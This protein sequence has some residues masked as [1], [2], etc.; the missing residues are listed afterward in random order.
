LTLLVSGRPGAKFSLTGERCTIG[1]EADND[2]ALAY[3]SVSRHHAE[4]AITSEGVHLR[5][6][7]S[8]N[9]THVN[10][11][12]RAE[13]WLQDGDKVTF[14]SVE[15]SFS[16]NA[17]PVEKKPAYEVAMRTELR[18]NETQREAMH[19]PEARPQRH[20]AAF[21]HM[22][23]WI[24]DGVE[25]AEGRTRWLEL[26]AASLGAQAIQYYS[27]KDKLEEV[28]VTEGAKPRV[29]FAHYL[30]EKF[31]ALAEPMS[32]RCGEL[33]R[34][35][36]RLGQY[37]FLVAPL[38]PEGA[39]SSTGSCPVVAVIRPE[40]WEPFAGDDRALLHSACRLWLRSGD[41]ARQVREL[42]TENV[43]LRQK[44]ASP[45]GPVL[46]GESEAMTRLRVRIAKIAAT[47]APVLI[48]GETG[49]GKEVV[50]SELHRQSPR[51]ANAFVKLNCAAIPVSL[52]ESEL[53]GHVK[54][55]FTD[56]RADRK[57]RFQLADG[58]TL[59]LDEVGELP[60]AVQ[61]KLLRVLETGD[62]EPIGS[63]K[64]VHV[65]VRILAATN[66]DLR[67][68]VHCGDFREDLLYRLEVGKIEVAPLRTHAEDIAEIAGCFLCKFCE[69]N[70]LAELHISPDALKLLKT[71]T[72]PG[73]VRE[74][75]NV[76]QR[77][78]MEAETS[79]IT[80]ADLKAVLG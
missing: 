24:T 18:Q 6:L 74:L 35:Q 11:V 40:T 46:L 41:K 38:R 2:I 10:G 61:A 60:L 42:K 19:L 7:G 29:K 8:R 16:T 78:A 34:F 15:M 62:V 5:D 48:T 25:E 20:L 47:R 30:L 13:A 4:I 57:G 28:H 37:H 59:F 72:W 80:A 33:D 52:V 70:G 68:R 75:R 43:E 32:Y 76:I 77:A 56:A 53:F 1:R 3:E 22:C 39:E 65:D 73:N 14:G 63:E 49:S 21:Y 50:A 66:R 54:G 45:N 58:G 71:Q 51:A 79:V 26:M 67:E 31:H 27:D 44:A 69:E 17:V 55:A 9:G 12:P 36:A 64:A 23:A